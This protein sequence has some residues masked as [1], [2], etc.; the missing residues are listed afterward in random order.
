M[1]RRI[2]Y[3]IFEIL[4]WVVLFAVEISCLIYIIKK[5]LF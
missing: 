3:W 1:V 4:P 2:K 5:V